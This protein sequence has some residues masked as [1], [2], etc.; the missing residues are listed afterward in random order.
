MLFRQRVKAI[1]HAI[2]F[3]NFVQNCI[4]RHYIPDFLRVEARHFT[5]TDSRMHQAQFGRS[6]EPFNGVSGSRSEFLRLLQ[7]VDFHIE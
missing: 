7:F 1:A 5:W 6:Y 3:L 4:S 2:E